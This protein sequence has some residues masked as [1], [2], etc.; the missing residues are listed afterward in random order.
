V[1]RRIVVVAGATATGKTGLGEAIAAALGGAV[2]CADAR[3]VFAELDIGT[4]KPTSAER[5]AQPHHLFDALALGE[6][7]SAGRW[8]KLA[9]G[10]CEALLARG[11]TPVLVGGSGL[12]LS[13]LI[14]GLHDEPP[15]D[16]GVRARLLARLAAE[17]PEAMHARLAGVDAETAARLAPRDGQRITRALEVFESSGR[18]LADWHA[19]APREALAADWRTL[20]LTCAAGSLDERIA[21]RTRA[22]FDSGLAQETAALVESGHG[23]ALAALRA[24]GYDEAMDLNA[25]RCDRADAEARTNRRTRQLA[26]RQR[27]WFRHQLDAVRL[28][29]GEGAA[30]AEL[31]DRALAALGLRGGGDAPGA[32]GGHGG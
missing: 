24:I 31:L 21:T 1:A 19:A 29:A 3:Q 4:G 13:A 30:P 26:K 25:G 16:P 27:T 15:H 20:E 18:T 5:A 2:V 8:A 23:N 28:D 7:A 32:G 6:R 12:Y 14:R 22:M 17:G 9:R 11:V 10:T